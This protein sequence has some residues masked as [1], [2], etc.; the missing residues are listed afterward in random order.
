MDILWGGWARVGRCPLGRIQ[1]KRRQAQPCR[2]RH[3]TLNVI[4]IFRRTVSDCGFHNR[5]QGRILMAPGQSN[6]I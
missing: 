4:Y 3:S 2:D 1:P 6:A 5:I